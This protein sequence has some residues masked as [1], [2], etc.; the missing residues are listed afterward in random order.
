MGREGKE[1]NFGDKIMRRNHTILLLLFITFTILSQTLEIPE[2]TVYGERRIK[3]EPVEK[4]LLP[5]EEE[6]LPP[7]YEKKIATLPL[8]GYF[9]RKL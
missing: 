7:Y 4:G 1:E 2:V 5:F 9:R 8:A 6:V 3:I